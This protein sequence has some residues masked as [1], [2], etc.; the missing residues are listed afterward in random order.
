MRISNVCNSRRLNC[1]NC[2]LYSRAPDVKIILSQRKNIG[3]CRI[4][5]TFKVTQVQ[6]TASSVSSFFSSFFCSAAGVSEVV[7][8]DAGASG[9]AAA[10]TSGPAALVSSETGSGLG[11]VVVML[12]FAF[13]AF[14]KAALKSFA[15]RHQSLN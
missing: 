15:S 12:T 3:E 5:K 8:A 4:S 13:C 9:A 14:S 2:T 1:H 11:T 7:G 10:G 6:F